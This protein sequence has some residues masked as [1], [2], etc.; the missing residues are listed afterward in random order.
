MVKEIHVHVREEAGM[1][2]YRCLE[3]ADTSADM[4]ERELDATCTCIRAVQYGQIIVIF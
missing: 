2:G 3:Q 4:P 1:K